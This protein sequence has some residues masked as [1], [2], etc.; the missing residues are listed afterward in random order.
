MR[1]VLFGRSRTVN[2][3][4][5]FKNYRG[6]VDPRFSHIRMHNAP[7]ALHSLSIKMDVCGTFLGMERGFRLNA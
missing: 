5:H 4:F 6:A 3:R 2:F 7:P 1:R